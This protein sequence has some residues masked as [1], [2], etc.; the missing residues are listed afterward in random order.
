MEFTIDN[1][2]LFIKWSM[3]ELS[4]NCKFIHRNCALDYKQES[5]LAKKIKEQNNNVEL[6]IYEVCKEIFTD[7]SI[8][9]KLEEFQNS[10]Y[11][12]DDLFELKED[13][14]REIV[15]FVGLFEIQSLSGTHWDIFFHTFYTFIKN[16]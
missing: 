12:E 13:F 15:Y 6:G 9:S 10:D 5:L 2:V 8:L 3:I 14:F 4:T 7:T 16:E 11:D 1:L